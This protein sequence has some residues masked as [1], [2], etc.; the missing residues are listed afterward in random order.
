LPPATAG[1]QQRRVRLPPK[2]ATDALWR[3]G[4]RY[5]A[6]AISTFGVCQ[7]FQRIAGSQQLMAD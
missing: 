7:N 2:A 4:V 5:S 3:L 1:A 6:Y